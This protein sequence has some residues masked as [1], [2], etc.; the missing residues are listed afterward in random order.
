MSPQHLHAAHGPARERGGVAREHEVEN[1]LSSVEH[2]APDGG[3]LFCLACWHPV[4]EWGPGG[5]RGRPR[6]RCPRCGALERHRFLAY[7]LHRLALFVASS[8][9]VLDIAPQPQVQRVLRDL[10]PH[11]YVGT[12]LSDHLGVDLLSDVTRLPFRDGA[13]D[14]VICYHV[15]EH[16]PDDA[17]A[18]A[19]LARVLAPSGLALV[20]VPWRSGEPT[21]EDPSAPP[22]ERARRFGQDDHVR[23]YGCD[24]EDR[25]A[26]AGLRPYR[27]R[28]AD[29]LDPGE[30]ERLALVPHE[31][32]WL[33]RRAG[34]RDPEPVL[35]GLRRTG[36]PTPSA[37]QAVEDARR[38][39]DELRAAYER[40]ATRRSVRAAL[41]LAGLAAPV[42]RAARRLRRR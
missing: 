23:H 5:T 16:V 19:E 29:L 33:C 1:G 17:A 18:M 7:V 30:L 40:L 25:L 31:A 11:A 12:D 9:A 2:D 10:A 39:A 36:A 8:R 28:P 20:Q 24:F 34:A 4:P 6:A 37:D 13:F 32:V 35:R 15:L 14:V 41:A 26:G 21:D 38:E 22:A 27:F 3:G 42:F